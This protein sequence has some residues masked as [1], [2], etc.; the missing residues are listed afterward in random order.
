M[1]LRCMCLVIHDPA[2]GIRKLSLAEASKHFT[3]I[4]LEL[5]PTSE[6]KPADERRR[7]RLRDLTGPVVGLKRSLA[8]VFILALALQA[9]AIVAPTSPL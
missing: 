4:A 1:R 3:G 7:L 5:S 8:Q 6:F 2:F 9:I